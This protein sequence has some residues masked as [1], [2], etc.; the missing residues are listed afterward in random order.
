M[1]L[2]VFDRKAK[3][4]AGTKDR[5]ANIIERETRFGLGC[6]FKPRRD[7]DVMDE[8]W[9]SFPVTQRMRDKAWTQ[10]ARAA[11]AITSWSSARSR[12]E[13]GSMT[14]ARASAKPPSTFLPANTWR[15]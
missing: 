5:L 12:L 8:D 3:T 11:A 10:L 9:T 7:H 6:S 1:K 4:I 15:F 2:T 14:P 13:L